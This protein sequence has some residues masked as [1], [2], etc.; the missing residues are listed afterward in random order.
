MSLRN[1]A[2]KCLT[3]DET[4]HLVYSSVLAL[5]G[6]LYHKVIYIIQ[7]VQLNCQKEKAVSILKKK[8]IF[9]YLPNPLLSTPSHVKSVLISFKC[10]ARSGNSLS[11]EKKQS[12][13][14]WYVAG[15]MRGKVKEI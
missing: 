5:L 6:S 4:L 10:P 13:D 11:V 15:D 3:T 9:S 7:C 2:S 1:I 14:N 8:V 12:D